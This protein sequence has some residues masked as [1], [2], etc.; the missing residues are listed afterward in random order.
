MAEIEAEIIIS[1]SGLDETFSQTIHARHSYI[2]EEIA[3]GSVFEDIL[4]RRKEDY[5]VEVNYDKFHSIRKIEKK[6]EG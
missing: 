2:A 4:Q 6:L 1:V 5:V 3:C